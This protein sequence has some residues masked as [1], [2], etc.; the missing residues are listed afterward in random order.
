MR[1]GQIAITLI[2]GLLLI[3]GVGSAQ[4]ATQ[5]PEMTEQPESNAEVTA[6]APSVA[7][8]PVPA[9]FS[10]HVV[11]PGENLFR[12]A[13]RYNTN[14]AALAAFNGIT[15]TRLIYVGQQIRIPSAAAPAAPTAAPTTPPATPTPPQ[16]GTATYT[17][18]AGDTLYR[19][20]VA[21]KTTVAQLATLN[22]LS[23][24]NVIFVGQQLTLPAAAAAPAAT[25]AP[26]ET[27][28]ASPSTT[29][30]QPND[31][32]GYGIEVFLNNQDVNALSSQ[33]TQLDLQWV[34]ITVS[35]RQVEANRGQLDLSEIEAAV[36]AFDAAGLNIL[37]TLTGAPDW[38]RESANNDSRILGEDGPPD[39]MALFG[40]FAGTVA[41]RF[42]GRVDAYE[43]WN[44]PNL[45]REWNSP[46]HKLGV[47]SYILMISEG[48]RAIKNADPDAK[49]ISAGLA[50]TGFN[51]GLNAVDDRVFLQDLFSNS[52][53]EMVN[54]IG[55]HPNGWANPPDSTCCNQPAGVDT[56]FDNRRFFFQDTLNDYRQIMIRNNASNVPIW[57]T[58][59]G[60]G[61][62]EGNVLV[63]PGA[64]NNFLSYTSQSEQALYIP[65]AFE[66]G[67]TSGVVG[68]MILNN[69]NACQA[70]QS[71][72]C[73]YSLIDA[74]GAA[75]PAFNA[76]QSINKQTE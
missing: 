39:D 41:G 6:E 19:I 29:V 55:A 53:T 49:I 43:I 30:S 14:V 25:I 21:N 28:A 2:L 52:V 10:V 27:A 8:T 23:N 51:D 62:S 9:G 69:L 54:A 17:V 22:R 11:Q 63:A 33:L 34:K 76:V 70:D 65:R 68:P 71:E 20:A 12:I 31:A 36:N 3:I 13:L 48:A 40:T 42:K 67:M 66:L 4:E 45:R 16:T 24:V 60:W 75:R 57:V 74:S 64:T 1:L 38:A 58:S 15:N 50:P 7:S 18:R 35:W 37:L 47:A 44:E 26:E 56:H 32:F 5:S 59:F 61:S 73:F 72:D 46:K